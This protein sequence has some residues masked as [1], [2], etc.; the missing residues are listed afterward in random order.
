[1][2]FTGVCDEWPVAAGHGPWGQAGEG[3][4]GQAAD[5]KSHGVG[6]P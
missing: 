2:Y 4:P 5:G 3:V 1:M 6:F